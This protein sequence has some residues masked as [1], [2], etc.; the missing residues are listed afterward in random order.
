VKW[1]RQINLGVE[2]G[3]MVGITKIETGIKQN[4][5]ISAFRW[6]L[7]RLAEIIGYW[8]WSRSCVQ[9]IL[10][11]SLAMPFLAKV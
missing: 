1:L 8:D 6:G 4:E 2:L 3:I 11:V 5:L 7:N 10:I 9:S